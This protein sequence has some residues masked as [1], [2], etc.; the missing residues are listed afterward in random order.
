M[1]P[2]DRIQWRCAAGCD[3]DVCGVCLYH[4]G[5]GESGWDGQRHLLQG[6]DDVW[7]DLDSDA[8][9]ACD[10]GLEGVLYTTVLHGGVYA[11]AGIAMH[12]HVTKNFVQ[13]VAPVIIPALSKA[14][15]KSQQQ[16]PRF[17]TW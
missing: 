12:D 1:W 8:Q 17:R 9:L 14:R 6:G 4:Q 7:G 11:R 3:F 15:T 13:E 5:A 16:Q 2:Q 10:T